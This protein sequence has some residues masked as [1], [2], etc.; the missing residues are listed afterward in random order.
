[1]SAMDACCDRIKSLHNQGQFEAAARIAAAALRERP[2]D[3]QLWE[4]LGIACHAMRDFA[5]AT[6]ALETA[7]MLAPLS[8]PAQVALAGCYLVSGHGDVAR[9]MYQHLAAV[10]DRLS[11]QLLPMVASGLSRL[12]ELHLALEVAR[13]WAR[14]EP[15]DESAVYAVVH[16][17]RLVE[18]PPELILPVAH[19]AF[20]LAPHRIRN[21]VALA[22]LHHQCGNL[23]EAYRLVTAVDAAQLIAA[24]CPARLLGLI[25]LFNVMG[26]TGRRDACRS[27]LA[28]ISNGRID[29]LQL[30]RNN[31][32]I[33]HK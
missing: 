13:V 17:M 26:D 29:W 19:H 3:A 5:A 22:L 2:N 8:L 31:R 7:T 23:V 32:L 33:L 21:R 18:Y 14:R 10:R 25:A 1:M 12:N 24:C 9:S 30:T 27:R 11:V 6:R 28:E 20:R 15:D 16:Y 4:L